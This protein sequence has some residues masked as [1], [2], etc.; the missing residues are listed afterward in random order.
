M[1][2]QLLGLEIGGTKLQIGAGDASGKL[3]WVM[4]RT[5][6]PERGASGI[7]AQILE[8]FAEAKKDRKLSAQP[9]HWG[10]GFGGPVHA[11]SGAILKSHQIEGWSEFPLAEWLRHE[12]GAQSVTVRNDADTAALAEAL[13]GAG[14]GCD[15]L[16]YVTVGSGIGGGLVVGG[17]IYEGAGRGAM[18]IGHLRV[19]APDTP[20][21]LI[22]LE[23]VASG[24][25]IQ[26]RS[27]KPSVQATFQA[28]ADGDAL[29][30]D[31]LRTAAESLGLGLSHVVH[32][33]A[34]RRIILGG[35]VSLLPDDV[36]ADVV[37]KSL[38]HHTMHVFR[39]MTDVVSA[40]LGE[41]VVVVGAVLL[42][43]AAVEIRN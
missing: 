25:S 14:Q 11:E 3:D 32:L 13:A 12:T 29:S 38:T 9:V 27:G 17:R 5:I 8:L 2:R 1:S 15:P 37:R 31:V 42:A 7:R 36:W 24:W 41:S 39:G 20:G 22:E 33:V 28:A 43:A 26:R 40:S 23:L 21:S 19:P 4:R 18:E 16:A 35:G 6:V 10:V 30:A 34:P